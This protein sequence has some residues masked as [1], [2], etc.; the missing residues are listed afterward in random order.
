MEIEISN[1]VKKYFPDV[2]AIYWFGSFASNQQTDESDVD[3]ALVLPNPMDKLTL[4]NITQEI[5]A[6]ISRD[7]DLIDLRDTPLDFKFE[8]IST[9]TLIFCKNSEQ[10]LQ[11]EAL[12]MS[13]YQ[14][15]SEERKGILEEIERSGKIFS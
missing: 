6:S 7:I 12:V 9:G 4:F 2:E 8:I 5:A 1:I 15:F 13:M 10:T 14:R 11:Y 3:L